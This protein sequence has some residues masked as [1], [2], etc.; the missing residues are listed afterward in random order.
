MHTLKQ[1]G[2]YNKLSNE[3]FIPRYIKN[4]PNLR[5]NLLKGLIGYKWNKIK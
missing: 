4:L 2:L 5:I 3:K 1:L